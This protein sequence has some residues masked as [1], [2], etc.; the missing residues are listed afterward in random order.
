MNKRLL[1]SIIILLTAVIALS[2]A[3]PAFVDREVQRSDSL[4]NAGNY[5][6]AVRNLD[7]LEKKI[8]RKDIRS[9][10]KILNTRSEAFL[11]IGNAPAMLKDLRVLIES[12]K[13]ADLWYF[14]A[15]AYLRLAEF[16]RE[17]KRFILN[18]KYIGKASEVVGKNGKRPGERELVEKL[19]HKIIMRKIRASIAS[20][21]AKV[22]LAQIERAIKKT[23]NIDDSLDLEMIRSDAYSHLNRIDSAA[24]ISSRLIADERLNPDVR[25]TVRMNLIRYLI[26]QNSLKAADEEWELLKPSSNA[27]YNLK[28]YLTG[29]DLAKAHG[30]EHTEYMYF[31][32]ANQIA[33]SLTGIYSNA[34]TQVEVDYFEVAAAN[35]EAELAR[36]ANRQRLWWIWGLAG[37]VALATAI[38]GFALLKSRRGRRRQVIIEKK[39]GSRN[40]EVGSLTRRQ[41]SM[42]QSQQEIRNIL[43]SKINDAEKVE[44]IKRSIQTSGDLESP[45]HMDIS[46]HDEA[47]GEFLAKLRIAHPNLTNAETRI[48]AFVWQNLSNKDIAAAINRSVSTVKYTKSSLKKKLATD[49]SLEEYLRGISAMDDTELA[50][51][52]NIK[53]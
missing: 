50:R 3:S 2:A 20:D 16:H 7:R 38:A 29:R 1:I 32:R 14:D 15:E 12:D 24:A 36:Q 49:I 43:A 9:L 27:H 37:L 19:R 47:T 21:S 31:K 33:D 46:R 25:N 52:A 22:G 45:R 17:Y 10:S 48:A 34:M 40:A 13:P 8:D 23:H 51:R 28:Y 41:A 11:Q 39:L 5:A 35:H 44:E 42:E 4:I 6:E 18:R 26:G 30:D 53:T